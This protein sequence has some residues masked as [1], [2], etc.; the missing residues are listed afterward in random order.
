[1]N[2]ASMDRLHESLCCLAEF[3]EDGAMAH[4]TFARWLPTEEEY[5]HGRDGQGIGLGLWLA[6]P[7]WL[8][9]GL[10]LFVLL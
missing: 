8:G 6:L 5:Q 4:R 7:L 9:L 10:C 1:M 3:L 2:V